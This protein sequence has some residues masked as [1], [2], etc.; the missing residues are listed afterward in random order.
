MSTVSVLDHGADPTG[1]ADSTAAFVAAQ[2]AAAQG[3]VLVP[4]GTYRVQPE[5]FNAW[6]V[7]WQGENVHHTNATK[8]KPWGTPTSGQAVWW[9]TAKTIVEDIQ[10]DAD[11]VADYALKVHQGSDSILRNV[12]CT[13]A[14]VAGALF[15]DASITI[16]NLASDANAGAGIHFLHCNGVQAHTIYAGNNGGVGIQVWGGARTKP[17]GSPA[18]WSQSGTFMAFGLTSDL[19]AG[20]QLVLTGAEYATIHGVY[21]EGAGHGIVLEDGAHGCEIVG[22]LCSGGDSEATPQPPGQGET[23]VAV[24]IKNAHANTVRLSV[25][26]GEYG[27]VKIDT[28]SKRNRIDCSFASRTVPGPVTRD[29][30]DPASL[31]TDWSATHDADGVPLASAPPTAGY[32]YKGDKVRNNGAA[33]SQFSEWTCVATGEPGTWTGSALID[34]G[35]VGPVIDQSVVASAANAA[36]AAVIG[37]TGATVNVTAAELQAALQALAD[38]LS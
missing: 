36:K 17:P 27:K 35:G 23:S 15:D 31:L 25:V 8:I 10:F 38:S 1:A 28:G 22:G 29:V 5:G 3:T 24:R 30:V 16:Y 6:A 33:A 11:G 20:Q 9:F 19:N 26:T 7:K 21:I 4:R 2:T 34:G 32:W 37:G 14:L 12:R 18:Y 13:G